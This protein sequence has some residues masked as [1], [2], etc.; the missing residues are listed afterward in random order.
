MAD[1][2]SSDDAPKVPFRLLYSTGDRGVFSS[3]PERVPNIC[4]KSVT[5]TSPGLVS[6][7]IRQP[8]ARE[9]SQALRHP[10]LGGRPFDASV[11]LGQVGLAH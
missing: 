9:G 8:H 6:H 4:Y 11:P 5:K 7:V 2:S 1:E 10:L 3:L